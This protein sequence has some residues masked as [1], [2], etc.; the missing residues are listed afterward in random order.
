MNGELILVKIIVSWESDFS[1]RIRIKKVS[2]TKK[3]IGKKVRK[4][5]GWLK[6]KN[7]CFSLQGAAI[8]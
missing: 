7:G 8:T 5:G 1:E 6:A 2:Y 3:E 4:R